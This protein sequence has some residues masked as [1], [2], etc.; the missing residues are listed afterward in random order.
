MNGISTLPLQSYTEG[1][2]DALHVGREF[3]GLGRFSRSVER[4]FVKP[5]PQSSRMKHT[6][7]RMARLRDREASTVER[8]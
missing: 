4:R 7:L 3:F 8:R 2:R 6:Q 1:Q 5:N